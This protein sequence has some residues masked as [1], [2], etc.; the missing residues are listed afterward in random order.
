MTSLNYIDIGLVNGTTYYYV[1]SAINL[2]GES[3]NSAQVTVTPGT[4]IAA[5]FEGNLIVN[6]QSADL[7]SSGKVWTNRTGDA[8]SVGNFSTIG[9]GNLNVTS[10]AWNGQTIGTLFV[11]GNGNNSVQSALPSPNEIIGHG[12]VSGETWVYATSVVPSSCMLNY[13]KQGG[14]ALPLEDREFNY[15][16]GGYGAFS[17]FF[18]NADMG[19]TLA[20]TTGA[21]HYLAYTYDGA[22]LKVYQ[23][24]NLDDTLSGVNLVTVPSFIQV[25][26]DIS[27]TNV[28]G[29]NDAFKGYIALARVESGVLTAGDI[30]ANYV[31]GPTATANAVAPIGLSATAGDSQV[32]LTWNASGNAT[33]YNLKHSTIANGTYSLIATNVSTLNFTNIGLVNGTTY[34]FTVSAT[35]EAG[36][37]VDSAPVSARPVSLAAPRLSSGLVNGQVQFTWAPDH[38][39]WRLQAQTNSLTTGFNTNWVTVSTS[40]S[41]NQMTLPLGPDGSAVFFRL[42]YP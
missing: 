29:G 14:S 20:P 31:L 26:S 36:S 27:G 19:W 1:V 40:N 5:H 22:S 15:E 35:N 33:G 28:N 21:W 16:T 10:L 25:G 7:K 11:G 38:T 42:V 23:D 12:P 8:N 37:S 4:N 2:W 13:G 30:A 24:G 18:G 41:T 3:T 6:L 39:G 9:G 34:Y 32:I 17:G